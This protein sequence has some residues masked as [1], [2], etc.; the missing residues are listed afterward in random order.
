MRVSLIIRNLRKNMKDY[1]IYFFTMMLSISLFYAFNSVQSEGAL[2][3]LGKDRLIMLKSLSS[4]ISITS[5]AISVI[6]AFLILYAN[7]FLLRRRKKEIG[8]YT[9]LGM[10]KH[11]IS[12]VFVGETFLVG[13]LSLV[14]GSLLG[15]FFSQ[16]LTII[17]LR[18]FGG[19]IE[20]FRLA[21][22]AAALGKTVRC[23]SVIYLIVMIFNACSVTKIK[24][25]DLMNADKK[26]EEIR[27]KKPYINLFILIVSLFFMAFG[28]WILSSD[29]MMTNQRWLF[30]S[31]IS[32][33]AGVVL[34]FYSAAASIM[35][36]LKKRENFYYK[37]VNAFL[38]RQIGN[39]IQSNYLS[40][41]ALTLML[42]LTVIL[43]TTGTSMAITMSELTKEYIPYDITIL[44]QADR[45]G[46]ISVFDAY[47]KDGI[48]LK[49]NLAEYI[50]IERRYDADLTY[51]TLLMGREEELWDLDQGLWEKPVYIL[52]LTDYNK[53][54]RLQG[55]EPVSLQEDEFLLNCNYKGTGNILNDFVKTNPTLTVGGTSLH[56][57]N[58]TI[59]KQVYMMTSIGNNDRGTLIVPD[60]VAEQCDISYHIL[61][62][63]AKTGV[64]LADFTQEISKIQFDDAGQYIKDSP[65][66]YSTRSLMLTMYYTM[67]AIPVFLCTYIGIV[68]LLICVAVLGLQQLTAT[69]DNRIRYQLLGKLGV[70]EHMIC[71]T[72][73]KQVAVYFAAPLIVAS[74][75]IVFGM[76]RVIGYISQSANMNIQAHSIVTLFLIIIIYGG[77]FGITYAACKK[78]ILR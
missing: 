45:V 62:G 2:L 14:V 44:A 33:I 16:F 22:S 13:L 48:E 12:L 52:S 43:I 65:Y 59:L 8:I 49:D 75:F 66:L 15:V 68:F 17:A 39:R 77:Y 37:G 67:M 57:K 1:G 7:M 74:V 21:F 3:S 27:E 32:L 9:L 46:D 41:A 28:V 35:K 70:T 29:T 73:F 58:P 38:I 11:Q 56:L 19:N 31:M 36:T 63:N 72:L 54:L 24:L 69:E 61:C 60:D 71:L 78:M 55:M 23:F 34:F 26:N 20:V 18:L 50:E 47:E 64:D 10:P 4:M 40:M 6:L 5:T 53:S 30:L 51:Q 25:I 76:N 42:T